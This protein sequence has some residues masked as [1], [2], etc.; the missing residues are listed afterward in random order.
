MTLQ[1]GPHPLKGGNFT[2]G[3]AGAAP[4]HPSARRAVSSHSPLICTPASEWLDPH[5]TKGLLGGKRPLSHPLLAAAFL[6]RS[7]PSASGRPGPASL[8]APRRLHF[9]ARRCVAG[10]AFWCFS[11]GPA[12]GRRGRWGRGGGRSR[13]S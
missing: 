10:V 3:G 4:G 13:P 8:Q 11:P 6:C 1:L 5:P 2:R 7:A 12:R 9:S